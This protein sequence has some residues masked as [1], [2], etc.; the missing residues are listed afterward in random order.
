MVFSY[1]YKTDDLIAAIDNNGKEAIYECSLS[2]CKNPVCTCGTIYLQ[3]VP[4]GFKDTEN[5]SQNQKMNDI[6]LNERKIDNPNDREISENFLGYMDEDDFNILEK[7]HF[8]YMNRLCEIAALYSFEVHFEF[9]Q[10]KYDGL[11]YSYNDVLPYG[12]QLQIKYN[13]KEYMI[14]DQYCL[15]PKMFMY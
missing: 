11:M 3:L 8:Q 5:N 10:V 6:D 9:D 14:L 13:D 7:Y 12:N 4:E 1:D 15:L 2:A